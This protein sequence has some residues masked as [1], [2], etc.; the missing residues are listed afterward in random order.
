MSTKTNLNTGIVEN[1]KTIIVYGNYPSATSFTF[2]INNIEFTPDEMVINSVSFDDASTGGADLTTAPLILVTTNL[3]LSTS[4]IMCLP[5]T[6]GIGNMQ[7]LDTYFKVTAPVNGT[8]TFFIGNA[9]TQGPPNTAMN[10]FNYY[11]AMTLTFYK[12]K[13]V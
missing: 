3:P 1:F 9:I 12:Y 11:L 8:Y 2:T 13:K 6:V 5:N 7:K 10:N 4:N